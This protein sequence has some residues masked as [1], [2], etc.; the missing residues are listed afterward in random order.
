MFAK[1]TVPAPLPSEIARP[2]LSAAERVAAFK[3]WEFMSDLELIGLHDDRTSE[4]HVALVLGNLGTMFAVVIYRHD[5]GLRW[6]HEVAT[7]RAAPDRYAGLE[8]N[9]YLKVE[10]TKK[11]ELEKPDLQTLQTAGFRPAGKGSVWP[12]FE[13]SQPGWYPWYIT[14]AEAQ[15]LTEHLRKVA[16]FV[17]LRERA[18]ILHEEPIEDDV[19]VVPAGEE[20]SLK[21]E[22]LEWVP[23]VPPPSPL[24][25]PVI[26]SA[27]EQEKLRSLPVRQNLVFEF[28]APLLT[29]LSFIDESVG[30]PCIGR[31]AM[32]VERRSH[33]L[34]GT[35]LSHGAGPLRDAVGPALVKALSA[36]QALPSAIHVDTEAMAATLRPACDVIGVPVRIAREL[37]AA[38]Q[39]IQSLESDQSRA[40]EK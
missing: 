5:A 18:G 37:K 34:L 27:E 8:N 7:T 4:L 39:A 33:L 10:W 36:A 19:P 38:Y 23:L 25:E 2:L 13:T 28:V 15:L 30:R 40:M 21:P 17:H 9:D 12:R 16:R 6:I 20:S 31:V 3:P 22:D 29:E 32:M 35:K 24:P 14:E 1:P 26:L 11:G